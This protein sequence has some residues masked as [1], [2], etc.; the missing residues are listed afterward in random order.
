[1][2]LVFGYVLM[3]GIYKYCFIKYLNDVGF[4]CKWIINDGI[5]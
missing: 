5:N 4:D 2:K 3:I 1:M